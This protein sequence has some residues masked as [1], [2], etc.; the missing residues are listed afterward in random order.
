MPAA[1]YDAH[2]QGCRR[3]TARYV[4]IIEEDIKC[5]GLDETK[6][7]CESEENTQ[8]E[9]EK[10]AEE[11]NDSDSSIEQNINITERRTKRPIKAPSRF[12]D[13]FGYYCITANYCNIFIP[14][15]FQEATTCDEAQS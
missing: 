7:S 3:I 14:D 15:T 11:K 9:S 5:I 4:D 2:R 6:E 10:T 13:E 1:T 8:L 12:D